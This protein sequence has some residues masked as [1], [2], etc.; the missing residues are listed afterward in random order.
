MLSDIWFLRPRL[1]GRKS[2]SC[3]E[4]LNFISGAFSEDNCERAKMTSAKLHT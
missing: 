4:R 2:R 1:L 3:Y